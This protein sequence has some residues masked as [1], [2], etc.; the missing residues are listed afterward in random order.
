M[1]NTLPG[2]QDQDEWWEWAHREERLNMQ[3]AQ[4]QRELEE[5][6]AVAVHHIELA[7]ENG[8]TELQERLWKVREELEEARAE[9]DRV[10]AT[11]AA[12]AIACGAL[13][14]AAEGSAGGKG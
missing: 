10:R 13:A 9:T 5:A 6:R 11:I 8:R 14:E 12:A 1:S 7:V 4:L 2:S 3:I